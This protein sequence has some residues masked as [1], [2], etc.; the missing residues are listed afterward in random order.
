MGTLTNSENSDEMPHCVVFQQGLHCLLKQM[1][2][3]GTEYII[4]L[5]FLPA[6]H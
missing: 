3:L 6:A 4:K 5:K 1:H 2:S